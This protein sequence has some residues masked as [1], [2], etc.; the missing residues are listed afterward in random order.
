MLVLFAYGPGQISTRRLMPRTSPHVTP[1]RLG[2]RE[3]LSKRQAT[4]EEHR[5]SLWKLNQLFARIGDRL[6][7]ERRWG[8]L[9]RVRLSSFYDETIAA[10]MRGDAELFRQ[11]LRLHLPNGEAEEY[12]A[13][14][15]LDREIDETWDRFAI[16]A[17]DEGGVAG[18][19]CRAY[20]PA[21]RTCDHRAVL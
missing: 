15:P 21:G 17:A 2:A 4:S 6:D 19:A 8:P 11:W 18:C 14:R 7:A 13:L 5:F 20:P 1:S 9:E 10:L 16:V 3:E 12:L